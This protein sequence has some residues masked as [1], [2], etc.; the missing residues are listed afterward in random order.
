MKALSFVCEVERHT[1]CRWAAS[2]SCVCH[3]ESAGAAVSSSTKPQ[4]HG[5]VAHTEQD[6]VDGESE[7]AAANRVAE[8]LD[9]L[10]AVGGVA[11]VSDAS[12]CSSHAASSQPLEAAS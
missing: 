12:Q 1:E 2:C 10:H 5:E 3:T 6:P 8:H 7:T 9:A 11:P 4:D